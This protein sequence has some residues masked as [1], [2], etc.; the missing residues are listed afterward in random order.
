LAIVCF[1]MAEELSALG[2]VAY[3]GERPLVRVKL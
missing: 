1:G 2:R 3:D